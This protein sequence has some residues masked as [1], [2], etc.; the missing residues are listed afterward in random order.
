ML[1]FNLTSSPGPELF[2]APLNALEPLT[3]V[4]DALKSFTG[5]TGLC[6]PLTY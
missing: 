1:M 4:R 3:G 2:L 6:Y 5:T